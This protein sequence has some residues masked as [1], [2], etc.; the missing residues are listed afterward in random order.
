ME[1]IIHRI[2]LINKLKEIPENFGVEIDIRS[3]KS[4]LILNHEPYF[5]G[6]KLS[7]FL[8]EYKHGTL[9]LNFKQAGIEEDVLSLINENKIKSYFLLD[10]EMPY[11]Y[12]SIIKNK[13]NVAVR[14]S[15]YE[16]IINAKNFINQV[17]WVWI[18]TVTKLPLD[19]S[20]I[21]ILKKFK[22]CLVCPERWGRQYDIKNYYNKMKK[23]DFFPNAVMTS[24]ETSFIWNDLINDK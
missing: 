4:D 22:S 21:R 6:D 19:K 8:K 23:L 11:F 24:L 18:D 10:I 9:V 14:F 13:K 15:E 1:L 17:D 20:K 2:N 5:N 7:D 16:D 12:N 3:Y